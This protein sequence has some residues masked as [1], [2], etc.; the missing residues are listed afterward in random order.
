MAP[1]NGYTVSSVNS[2]CVK[3]YDE[4][5]IV[6]EAGGFAPIQWFLKYC[7]SHVSIDEAEVEPPR[8]RRKVR[9]HWNLYRTSIETYDGIN[10]PIHKAVVDFVF[11]QSLQARPVSRQD[12]EGNLSFEAA[13]IID[14]VPHGIDVDEGS[15]LTMRFTSNTPSSPVLL[16]NISSVAKPVLDVLKSYASLGAVQAS[17][18]GTRARINPASLVRCTLRRSLGNLHNVVRL[19]VSV[20]WRSGVSAFPQG[21]PVGV[22]RIYDDYE[23]LAEAYP[24][25]ARVEIDHTQ[26]WS[27][28]EFYDSVHVPEKNEEV[29]AKYDGVLD[30]DL[31]PFQKRAL[32]W[33]LL[34]EGVAV[35]INGKVAKLIES[36]RPKQ[37]QRIWNPIHDAEGNTCFVNHLQASII[38]ELPPEDHTLSGGLLAEEMGLG[39]TVE[40]L[41]LIALHR[42][43]DHDGRQIWD[44]VSQTKVTTSQATLIITPPS[45]MQQ[46]MSELARHA[47]A[48][49]VHQYM[50]VGYG[51]R[52]AKPT[53]D[54]INE[55]CTQYDV[56]LATYQTLA[57]EL[58][59]A[60]DPPDRARRRERKFERKRSPLVQIR[61]WRVCLDEAQMV[62]SGVT[63]AARVACRL[64]RVHSWAVTGTPLRKNVQ[65][66][67]GLLI[68]LRYRPLSESSKL[69]GHLV[70]NHR[71]ILRKIWGD[72]ALRHTKSH[73]REEL[74]LPPQKRIVLSVPFSAVEQQHYATLFDEMCDAVGVTA[75]GSPKDEE[76]DPANTA[77]VE[78]MRSWLIRLRQTCLHPQVGGRNRKKLGRGK[79]PLRTVAEVLE[80]MIEQ[81]EASVRT[82]ERDLLGSRL[83]R[84]HIVGNNGLDVHRAEAALA[85]YKTAMTTSEMLVQDA[86]AR[87]AAVKATMTDDD[88]PTADVQDE[89][90]S[91][92]STPLLGQLRHGLRT[93]LQLQHA[94]T[95]FAATAVFQ[96]KSNE[97]LTPHGSDCFTTLENEEQ[98]LYDAAKQLRKEILLESSRKAESTMRKI[99]E[100][101]KPDLPKIKDLEMVGI[102]ARRLVEKSDELFDVVREQG[103]HLS[104]M[105]RKMAEYLLK[106]LVDDDKDDMETT[107]DEYEN[108]T[109]QQDELY[110]YFDAIKAM[111]A[112]LNTFITGEDAPLIDHEVKTLIQEARWYLNPDYENHSVVH[113]PELLLEL[114]ETRN[115][116]RRRKDEVGSVRGLIQDARALEIGLDLKG[117][118]RAE[119]ERSV[120]QQHLKNLQKVF[121]DYTKVLASLEND[122]DWYRAAQNS[123]IEFYRQM[124]EL[125]DAVAPYKEELDPTLDTVALAE[126][127]KRE[128][129]QSQAL[130]THKTKNRFLKHLREDNR[131]QDTPRICVI[132]RCDF[133]SGVLTVC[134]HQYCKECIGHWWRAHH[135]CPVC[136]RRLSKMDFHDITYK[137][138]KLKAQ[139]EVH[140]MSSS[141]GAEASPSTPSV[142]TSIYSDVDSKLMDQ[143][144]SI[145]LP[146]SYGTKIDTLGR[147]LHWIREHDPG[148]KSI[149]FSQYRDF[150]DVLSG[151]LHEFKVGCS[152]VGRAGAIEKFR[153]DPSI[154][155]LLLDAK[156]D[157]SGLTLVNA[158]NV[159]I[160]EPLIQ[161]AVELQ[162][163][164]RVHRI[165]QT[166][167]TTVWMYLVNDTVEEAIYEISVNRRLAHAQSRQRHGKS[168]STT[169]APLHENAIEAANS[170]ELQSAPMSKLLVSGKSGGELVRNDD[171]WQCLFG[172]AQKNL[173]AH[174]NVE[175]GREVERH[176][177][178]EAAVARLEG[179]VE[180]GAGSLGG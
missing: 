99:K 157:S 118:K 87:L 91:A 120:I 81:N 73:I 5:T 49:R 140:S 92:E 84:A 56:V 3:S 55:C 166:R 117:D 52:N 133:V 136:K 122:L 111:Q 24:D 127:M 130:A 76:W 43:G 145:D 66:L 21:M 123:R 9:P 44:E 7:T 146:S 71:H 128:E 139:E 113:A 89:E 19:E 96:I 16:V 68:F 135:T 170:A 173:M 105:R 163:I 115:M 20:Y 70:K 156:T 83:L 126:I 150:L 64:P 15:G 78:A 11:P 69:W 59:F 35:D 124:Q 177:R 175:M 110:V 104:A 107:G 132:C 28:Q 82:V 144:K 161:T 172:K 112:D 1:T 102:E 158:T 23:L 17:L 103:E 94:C 97:I 155:C 134:G 80:T 137:P 143:I 106:P 30:S 119:V 151:A 42:G 152:R 6:V 8:K 100:T 116:Y 153:H 4:K 45:I 164:A 101:M 25:A 168:R 93:A 108:S 138:Q 165:G 125:S 167:P 32:S 176:L 57:R 33:M 40:L 148:A 37:S 2:T 39:K 47:P 63:A 129:A 38:R 180:E 58:H 77:I 159:F 62:E 141:P 79:G 85:R 65:D 14:V 53:S 48:L 26:P 174:P 29:A 41:A 171:L 162:A 10:I 34:R 50:G 54:V 18:N 147:H 74:R 179:E 67:H 51:G 27:P 95:F 160:C 98:E 109:K 13:E 154:D 12:I 149:V 169:P 72:I 131:Q 88:E 31:Y 75:D 36:A 61:W 114:L 142:Q 46:W 178:A 22:P 86:R 121:I 90:S 60:E